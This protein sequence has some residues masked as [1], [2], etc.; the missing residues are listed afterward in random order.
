LLK[1]YF[2]ALKGLKIQTH[3]EK[4]IKNEN[5]G[6]RRKTVKK[7]EPFDGQVIQAKLHGPKNVPRIVY[8]RNFKERKKESKQRE[9]EEQTRKSANG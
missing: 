2:W 7:C 4:E 1:K 6:Q 5:L 3:C 8:L 9:S